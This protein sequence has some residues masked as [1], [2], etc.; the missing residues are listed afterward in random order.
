M[1]ARGSEPDIY[2]SNSHPK[3][4]RSS[5]VLN[6]AHF[7]SP[8]HLEQMQPKRIERANQNTKSKWSQTLPN[9]QNAHTAMAT[10][11]TVTQYPLAW[12]RFIAE[13]G[14]LDVAEVVPLGKVPL[15]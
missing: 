2:E 10:T 3:S 12:S 8:G 9:A 7:H 4:S 11:A 13:V 6:A 14:A 15:I 5:K 1:Q